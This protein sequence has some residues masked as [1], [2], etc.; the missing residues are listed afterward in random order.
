MWLYYR[1]GIFLYCTFQTQFRRL[2]ISKS[3]LLTTQYTRTLLGLPATE[4]VIWARVGDHA[5]A[6]ATTPCTLATY[7]GPVLPYVYNFIAGGLRR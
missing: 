4:I 1:N 7:F 2:L 6:S 3:G 5:H